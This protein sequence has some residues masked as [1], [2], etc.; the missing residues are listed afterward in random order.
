MPN[1][2]EIV[3][4]SMRMHNFVSII[5]QNLLRIDSYVQ[6]HRFYPLKYELKKWPLMINLILKESVYIFPAS[7]RMS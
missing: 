3:G 7:F 6:F 2:G 5:S 1:V 4:G